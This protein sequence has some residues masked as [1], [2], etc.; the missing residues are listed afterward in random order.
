MVPNGLGQQGVGTMFVKFFIFTTVHFLL[1]WLFYVV[2]EID[3]WASRAF[4][5][6]GRG[7]FLGTSSSQKVLPYLGW[8]TGIFILGSVALS[9]VN[10]LRSRKP[11][12]EK[13]LLVPNRHLAFLLL[14]LAIGPGFL[15]NS[16][17]KSHGGRARPYAV[18]EFGGTKSFSPAYV[19]SDQCKKNCSFVSGD[20]AIGYFVLLFLFVLRKWARHVVVS[21]ILLGTTIGLIRIAQGAHFLSDV[22]FAGFLTVSVGWFL[23]F[24]MLRRD[25]TSRQ[26]WPEV[27]G[28][29]P[30][31]IVARK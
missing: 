9:V 26:V 15:I 29:T 18:V 30:V 27:L 13:I 28:D 1:A 4:F 14:S 24:L 16:F 11:S 23:S 12:P 7:F 5:E 31:K 8:V 17:L 22:I 10:W 3:L 20:A 2:P 6:P 25:L 19:V 21:G